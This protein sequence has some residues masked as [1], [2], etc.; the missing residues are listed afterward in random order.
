MLQGLCR[1][2]VQ[3]VANL[4]QSAYVAIRS[5]IN[6]LRCEATEFLETFCVLFVHG[7]ANCFTPCLVYEGTTGSLGQ[8]SKPLNRFRLF[9]S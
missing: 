5:Q 9:G 8:T 2:A 6:Q 4:A 1:L 7:D 3:P